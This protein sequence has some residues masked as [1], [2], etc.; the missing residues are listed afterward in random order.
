VSGGHHQISHHE[1]DK[2]KLEEY[3]KINLWHIQQYAYMVA[4]MRGIKEGNSTLLDNSMVLFG[5]G[6]R[7]GNAHSPYNLPIVVAG[8]GGG[9]LAT[10]RHLKYEPK[11]PL[12]GLYRTMLNCVGAPVHA[13]GDSSNELPGL[14]D[15]DFKGI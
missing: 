12:C 1:N 14:T 5:S 8:K 13:L 11:T 2:A 6:M 7:D 10:G 9:K 3:Q 4:R 15:P